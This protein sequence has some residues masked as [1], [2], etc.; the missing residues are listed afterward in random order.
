MP[1]FCDSKAWRPNKGFQRTA[2]CA[3]QDRG[4]FDRWYRLKGFPAPSMRRR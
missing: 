1:S 4:Y 3:E 2:L